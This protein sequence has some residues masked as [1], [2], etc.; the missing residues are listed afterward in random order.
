MDVREGGE[1]SETVRL[2]VSWKVVMLHVSGV[3]CWRSRSGNAETAEVARASVA[4]AAAKN[5]FIVFD[6][7]N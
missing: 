7:M 1:N 4:A 3:F 5:D 6:S 2:T